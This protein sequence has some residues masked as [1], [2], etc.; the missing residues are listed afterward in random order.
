MRA[1][2]VKP[3]V[4]HTTV[5]IKER[6]QEKAQDHGVTKNAPMSVDEFKAAGN[7]VNTRTD[8]HKEYAGAPKINESKD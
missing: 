2:T 6:Y 1:E 4:T 3:S 7:D 5:P 8:I